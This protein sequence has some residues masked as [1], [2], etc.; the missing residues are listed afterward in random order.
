MVKNGVQFSLFKTAA[1]KKKID[2]NNGCQG[3]SMDFCTEIAY[4]FFS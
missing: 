4:L 3:L 2:E 1:E